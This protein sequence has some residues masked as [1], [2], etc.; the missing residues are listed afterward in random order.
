MVAEDLSN[1]SLAH[2][3]VSETAVKGWSEARGGGKRFEWM[4][5]KLKAGLAD[6]KRTSPL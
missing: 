4:D 6:S 2:L 5:V 3:R 1:G